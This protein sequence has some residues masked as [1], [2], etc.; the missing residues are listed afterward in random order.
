MP[1]KVS[2]NNLKPATKRRT[3]VS[4]LNASCQLFSEFGYA[5]TTLAMI[6]KK[7]KIGVRVIYKYFTSKEAI[8]DQLL[9]VVLPRMDNQIFNLYSDHG[10]SPQERLAKIKIDADKFW[11]QGIQYCLVPRL[12]I[13]FKNSKDV[14]TSLLKKHYH[15]W[16]RF[17]SLLCSAVHGLSN[18]EVIVEDVWLNIFMTAF[19]CLASGNLLPLH[20]LVHHARLESMSKNHISQFLDCLYNDG[21]PFI[22]LE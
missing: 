5:V 9:Q 13:E 12:F 1:R 2:A 10:L 16:Y 15:D 8:L 3:V 7:A 17:I 19:I 22:M 11:L 4:I 20:G 14:F 18:E 6:A 21:K